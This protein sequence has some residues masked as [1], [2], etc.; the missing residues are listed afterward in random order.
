[1]HSCRKIFKLFTRFSLDKSGLKN[2][3]IGQFQNF[4]TPDVRARGAGAATPDWSHWLGGLLVTNG[5]GAA[6][7]HCTL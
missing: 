5:S 3:A 1:M 7:L 6:P 4:M 2:L